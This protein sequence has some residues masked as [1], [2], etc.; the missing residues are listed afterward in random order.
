LIEADNPAQA[1]TI[2]IAQKLHSK[3]SLSCLEISAELLV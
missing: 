3:T 1:I 2:L